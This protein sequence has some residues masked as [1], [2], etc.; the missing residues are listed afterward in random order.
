MAGPEVARPFVEAARATQPSPI[1]PSQYLDA[2]L[3]VTNVPQAIWVDE[4]SM[5]VRPPGPAS[6][7]PVGDAAQQMVELIEDMEDRQRSMAMI[8]DWVEKGSESRY[9]LLPDQVIAR[10]LARS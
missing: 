2:P 6:P 10:S 9:A 7:L 3:G 8:A 1:D 5:I 4:N